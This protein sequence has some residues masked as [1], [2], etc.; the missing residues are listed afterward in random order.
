MRMNRGVRKKE[1][2]GGGGGDQGGKGEK[3]LAIK[4]TRPSLEPHTHKKKRNT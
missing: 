4:A 1:G 2:G 3:R